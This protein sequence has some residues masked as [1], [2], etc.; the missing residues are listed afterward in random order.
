MARARSPV[1]RAL[2]R[3]A[4]NPATPPGRG[5]PPRPGPR[6]GRPPPPPPRGP[7][8]GEP[9]PRG[10][11][12]PP[13]PQ[14]PPRPAPTGRRV[15]SPGVARFNSRHMA[16]DWSIRSGAGALRLTGVERRTER[17]HQP[18]ILKRIQNR[19]SPASVVPSWLG[20]GKPSR[21][22]P[23]AKNSFSATMNV[24]DCATWIAKQPASPRH[25]MRA[26]GSV[27][28]CA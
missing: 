17:R 12:R 20:L 16:T 21:L 15:P 9:P 26:S 2:P 8:G 25:H 19:A 24:I 7:R 18:G 5:G 1:S 22:E 14:P 27:T 6:P 23:G 3:R 11:P 4:A 10:R 13:L 28:G